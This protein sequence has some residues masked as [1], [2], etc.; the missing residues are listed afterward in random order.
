MFKD[1]DSVEIPYTCKLCLQELKFTV[2][3]DEYKAV[4]K[5][6]IRKEITHGDPKHILIAYLNQYLEVENFEIKELKEK[7]DVASLRLI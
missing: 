7:K 3:K 6:P 1:K 5:F 2:T 4:N